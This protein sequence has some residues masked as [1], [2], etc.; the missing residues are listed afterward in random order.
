MFSYHSTADCS[1]CTVALENETGD[2]HTGALVSLF[3]HRYK[4]NF[5]THII[6]ITGICWFGKRMLGI[7]NENCNFKMVAN[8]TFE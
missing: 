8:I 1:C 4:K 3:L 5:M 7:I 6:S 2:M